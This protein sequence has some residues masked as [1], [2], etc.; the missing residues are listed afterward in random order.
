MGLQ[1][2]YGIT[3]GSGTN[4]VEREKYLRAAAEKEGLSFPA[5]IKQTL[6]SKA[7]EVMGAPDKV[8]GTV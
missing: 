3:F 1:S 5:W 7:N 2:R 6:L 4:G 8:G